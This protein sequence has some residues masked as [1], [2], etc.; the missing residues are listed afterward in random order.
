MLK[1]GQTVN[2]E[3]EASISLTVTATNT[4]N[5]A[6]V[7]TTT[8]ITI[9]VTD[10]NEFVVTT[11]SDLNGT[12]NAIDENSTG[13]VGITAH[14]SDP[15][16][17]NNTV[18][19]SLVSNGTGN[20]AYSGPF[21]IDGS[22][23]VVSLASPLD[24]EVTGPGTT[25][26]I[27]ATSSD[28]S[29]AV[30]SFNVTLNDLNDNAAV[31]TTATSQTIAE[32]TRLVTAL[33]STD[34]DTVGQNP[35]LFSIAGGADAALFDISNGN[36]VFKT[37]RDFETQPHS[38]T[39][40]VVADDGA[41][42]TTATLTVNISNVN[43]APTAVEL[44]NA[45]TLI[46]ENTSTAAHIKVADINVTDD[47]L[48]TNTLTLAG[49]DMAS[50]EISGG[51]LFLKAGVLLDFET[52][53]SYDVTVL[54]SDATV[55]GSSPVTAGFTL[56]V[57]NVN[58][59]PAILSNGGGDAASV[60]INENSTSVATVH[61]VD[62]DAGTALT[63]AIAGGLDAARFSI[64]ATTGALSFVTGPDFEVPTDSNHDNVYDVIV[65]ASDGS[66]SDLQSLAV[67][68]ANV[69]GTFTGNNF[70]NTITGS[71][72]EDVIQGLGGND[73]LSGLAGNDLIVG[74]FGRDIMTGGTGADIFDFNAVAESGKTAATRD[75]LRDFEHGI[76]KIDLSTIDAR[77]NHAGNDAFIWRVT[78]GFTGVA[79]QLHYTQQNLP[80][81]VNDKTII[82]GDINGDRVADFQIE[83][84]GLINL[85][86]ADFI[87]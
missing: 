44:A 42:Q 68:V 80:G 7:I 5:P 86:T 47:A 9:S 57:S 14:A 78:D 1:A 59:A 28:G 71:N 67:H 85:T 84:K 18:T 79:G 6:H 26:F 66:L 50:F 34:A 65:Q 29:S 63:Y 72:E 15:D 61:A 3:V 25:L 36:L 10:V 39:V 13:I 55:V 64:N 33:T 31:I 24:Y 19:Y 40:A 16:G 21:A 12:A 35:A 77:T 73:N 45:I 54:A 76:D 49:A 37:A 81:T 11:P 30:A 27:K 69:S 43:E 8:P 56:N 17:S 46:A 87:L 48:G 22:T 74:G 60:T 51:Q 20:A 53:S 58:E 83:L 2:F 4:D 62:P 23:G 70:A 75:V 32:N 41:H 82:E 38:Y 52:K